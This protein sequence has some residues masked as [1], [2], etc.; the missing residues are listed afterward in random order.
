[1]NLLMQS[2]Q[3]IHTHR[4]AGDE[5]AAQPF[6]RRLTILCDLGNRGKQRRLMKPKST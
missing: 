3:H 1:L 2:R 4:Y 5:G 6:G